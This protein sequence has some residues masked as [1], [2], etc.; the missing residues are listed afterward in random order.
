MVSQVERQSQENSA[1]RSNNFGGLN[2]T[3]SLLN[4][5]FED[6]PD[7]LNMEVDLAGNLN[8]RQ[9]TD[10]VLAFTNSGSTPV[11]YCYPIRTTLGYELI[12][13]KNG[14]S[15]EFLYAQQ[16]IWGA[17]KSFTNV[18]QAGANQPNTCLIP[19]TEAKL[20]MLT[21]NQQPVQVR[22]VEQTR[23]AVSSG[24]NTFVIPNAQRF[25]N[26]ATDEPI[27]F[28]NGSLISST[29]TTFSY[30]AG[31]GDLTITFTAGIIAAA[32]TYK[33]DLILPVWQRWVEAIK[34]FGDRFYDTLTR[35]DVSKADQ[36]VSIP[37]PLRSDIQTVA[38]DPANYPIRAYT[39]ANPGAQISGSPTRQP[40]AT[41]GNYGF[42]D[43][44]NYTVGADNYINPAPF[45]L[46]FADRPS[47]TATAVGAQTTLHV[48]RYRELRFRGDRGIGADTLQVRVNGV[49]Q[50]WATATTT[51]ANT[52]F[53]S[54]NPG[55]LI[56]SP[57]NALAT[58]VA[59]G[60]SNPI[61]V[62]ALSVVELINTAVVSIGSAAS[63]STNP[64]TQGSCVPIYGLGQWAD[65]F[66]GAYPSLACVHQGRL[67]LS[68]FPNDPTRVV[69]SRV[70]SSLE[71]TNWDF[72]QITDDLEG[73]ATDPFDISITSS[74][75]DDFVTGL[76]D[77]GGFLF[78]LSRRAVSRVS[79]SQ[80]SVLSGSS[81]QVS[82]LSSQGLLNP[83]CIARTEN[84]IFYVSDA[85]VFNLI[86]READGE[87]QAYEKTLKVR[88]FFQGNNPSYAASAWMS[89]D[90]LRK[91]LFLGLPRSGDTAG[92][93]SNLLVFNIQRE[94]WS[95][96]EAVGGFQSYQGYSFRDN[97]LGLN[98]A[99]NCNR[100]N[101]TVLATLGSN[102][103][104]DFTTVATVNGTSTL[105]RSLRGNTYARFSPFNTQPDTGR[106]FGTATLTNG[107]QQIGSL[108]WSIP[109]NP[110]PDYQVVEGTT[111]IT[112]LVVRKADG[113]LYLND[114]NPGTRTLTYFLKRITGQSFES[115][116]LYQGFIQNEIVIWRGNE[117]QI[118]GVDYT[119]DSL[120][121]CTFTSAFTGNIVEHGYAYPCYY[122]S[123]LFT[124]GDMASVK[125]FKHLYLYFENIDYQNTK[126]FGTVPDDFI[127]DFS[128]TVN[129]NVAILFDSERDGAV[130]WDVYGFSDIAWDEGYF[131]APSPAEQGQRYSLFREPL[132]GV[133]YSN[134]FLIFS[135]DHS[136]FKL[137]GYQLDL[138]QKGKT[139]KGRRV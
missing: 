102:R 130:S 34:Y 101:D 42:G 6:S 137:A 32:T 12:V 135:F 3:S 11:Y 87:Y 121:V 124:F 22:F 91:Y 29:D 74:T 134:Q 92:K 112:S 68:G 100:G 111:D 38:N 18:W 95:R 105:D 21:G 27:T 9:G 85:G 110:A 2:T 28:V 107:S 132:T 33:V 43:G 70:Q 116:S 71:A 84:A 127:G 98:F 15:L 115:S 129:A 5:P 93:A 30:N 81:V 1:I 125:R 120:G 96:W 17:A 69:F 86:P 26:A 128:N 99:L 126:A 79:S 25:A 114:A 36:N 41:S 44:A 63:T 58:Y 35:F 23:T 113:S 37:A 76:V 40:V 122:L 19:D 57:T 20:L 82:Y 13:T 66:T 7:L 61:G 64:L 139:Y 88:R 60:S 55:T 109:Y 106:V 45:F 51:T 62:G 123:P 56:T 16:Q 47:G 119:I 90:P 39:T 104:T 72:F 73:L 78:I 89:Y 80:G 49:N 83:R 108:A 94:S 118:Q 103:Y 53:L 52:Y 4:L 14:T 46:T 136:A 131:D 75:L 50:T 65:S 67:V 31:T 54:T 77:W 117:L 97:V 138:Q 10:T 8:K 24:V 48:L 59:F 133:G